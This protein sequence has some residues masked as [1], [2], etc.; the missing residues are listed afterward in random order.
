[1]N[2]RASSEMELESGTSFLLMIS[3][4]FSS[5]HLP[6]NGARPCNNSFF[7]IINYTYRMIPNDHTS[8]L[9]PCFSLHTTSGGMYSVVPHKSGSANAYP[10]SFVAQLKS[11]IF[12]LSSIVIKIFSGLIIFY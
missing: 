6:L 5:L 10:L 7:I 3:F 2:V 8:T 11:Q 1:M 12:T 9:N 4:I